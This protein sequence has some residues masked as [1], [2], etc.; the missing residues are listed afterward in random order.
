MHLMWCDVAINDVKEILKT[1]NLMKNVQVASFFCCCCGFFY[2][3]NVCHICILYLVILLRHSCQSHDSL[4]LFQYYFSK[5]LGYAIQWINFCSN[6][7]LFYVSYIHRHAS[8]YLQY[9]QTNE[10]VWKYFKNPWKSFNW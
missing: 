2:L 7:Y 9:K 10:N 8:A 1:H 3:L 4:W 6:S 5:T